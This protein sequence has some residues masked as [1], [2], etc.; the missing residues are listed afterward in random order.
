MIETAVSAFAKVVESVKSEAIAKSAIDG[1]TSELAGSGVHRVTF[2]GDVGKLAIGGDVRSVLSALGVTPEV[3]GSEVRATALNAATVERVPL[4]DSSGDVR[5]H[6]AAEEAAH[7]DKIGLR[8][9]EVNGR[10]CLV[11]DDINWEQQDAY[12]Q[13]NKERAAQGLA[14]LDSAG[15]PY[16]LH[17]VEQKSDG[18]LAELTRDEH[19]GAGIDRILHDPTKTSEIDR[20]EFDKIRADHWRARAAEVE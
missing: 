7:Y 19:R 3:L 20:A 10:E 14:P 4:A 8:A 18:M 13:T 17:H 12:G 15:R 2:G 6:V 16:E 1:L 9:K 11:R 5:H